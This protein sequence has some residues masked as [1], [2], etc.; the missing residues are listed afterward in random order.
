[1]AVNP[2]PFAV[3]VDL[4]TRTTAGDPFDRIPVALLLAVQF[5]TMTWTVPFVDSPM[6]PALP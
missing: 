4:V 5:R 6:M 1:M 3:I 2:V